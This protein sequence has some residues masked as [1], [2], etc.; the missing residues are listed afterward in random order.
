MS[1]AGPTPRRRLLRRAKRAVPEGPDPA[2]VRRERRR[3]AVLGLVLVSLA[4]TAWVWFEEKQ[5]PKRAPREVQ[6]IADGL[7]AAGHSVDVVARNTNGGWSVL[8][9]DGEVQWFRELQKRQAQLHPIRLMH[10]ARPDPN[11]VVLD[12]HPT[13]FAIVM[14]GRRQGSTLELGTAPTSAEDIAASVRTAVGLP[15]PA[16]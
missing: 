4:T 1:T 5:A 6:R 2:D 11:V 15:L 16:R 9:D 13:V 12:L 10:A 14:S 3:L 8:F 7:Q